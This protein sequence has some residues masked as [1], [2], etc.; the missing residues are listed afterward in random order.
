LTLIEIAAIVLAALVIGAGAGALWMRAAARRVSADVL[1]QAVSEASQLARVEVATLTERLAA[2]QRALLALERRL[3]LSQ[4]ELEQVR[5]EGARAREN[6]AGLLVELEQ[7]RIAARDKLAL[8]EQAREALTAQFKL[9][10]N[11]ILEEKS[12]RFAEQNRS[13][14]DLL[15]KPLGDKLQSFEKKVEDTYITEAKERFSLGEEV[16][17]LQLLNL[18]IGQDAVNLTRALKGDAKTR[19]NW[20]EVVLERILERSGLEKGREYETQVTVAGESGVLRPDVVVRLPDDKHIVIDSK[21][22]L[23]AYDRYYSAESDAERERA[24]REHIA[25]MRRHMDDLAS[26][27]YQG[28]AG[29]N[30]PDFVAMFVPI[31]PAFNLAAG[32]DDGLVLDAFDRKVVIVTP[33]TLLAMLSTVASL[34]K[35]ELQ[36]RNAVEIAPQSGEL[37]DKFVGFVEALKDI[38]ARLDA[39]RIA[40]DTAYKR[41][42]GGHG[43]LVGRVQKL[44]KLGARADKSLPPELVESAAEEDGAA[45][46]PLGPTLPESSGKD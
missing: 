2:G 17:K 45:I 46:L 41:L 29:I 20:G 36:T 14:L 12:R 30:A 1:A 33:N 10:A 23:V 39:A 35:R 21:V 31:E 44:K 3:E 42:S 32:H 18:Q 19:G 37:Y 15:L 34:W 38:G 27:N 5:A 28:R 22:S 8:L 40:Y 24:L 25:S 13:Q 7:E 43:N 11:E 16:K 9:L 26:K 6:N 4:I